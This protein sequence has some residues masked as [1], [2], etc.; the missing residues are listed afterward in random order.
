VFAGTAWR[1]RS[2]IC[3]RCSMTVLQRIGNRA[4][5][6]LLSFGPLGPLLEIAPLAKAADRHRGN[7]LNAS[8]RA[9][10]FSASVPITL[11]GWF[12]RAMPRKRLRSSRTRRKL[13]PNYQDN[14]SLL[15]WGRARAG[16]FMAGEGHHSQLRVIGERG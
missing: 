10:T 11:G 4:R 2:P 13:N 15:C 5:K 3:L 1:A 7:G 9:E 16:P 14:Q 8:A 6:V 12:V